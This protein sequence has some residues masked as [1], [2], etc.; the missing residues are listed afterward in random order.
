MNIQIGEKN[1]FLEIILYWGSDKTDIGKTD[2][3]DKTLVI[4][5]S[6]NIRQL[7]IV[8]TLTTPF[9]HGSFIYE[10]TKENSSMSNLIDNLAIYG[11]ISFVRLVGNDNFFTDVKPYADEF[12][13]ENIFI[14]RIETIDGYCRNT[15]LLKFS[16]ASEDILKFNSKIEGVSTFNKDLLSDSTTESVNTVIRKLF[17]SVNLDNK[18]DIKSFERN[19]DIQISYIN[20]ANDNLTN[21]LE[22]VYR[23]TFDD[24]F[25][26]ASNCRYIRILYDHTSG[27]YKQWSYDDFGT[28]KLLHNNNS[29]DST[30]DRNNL[31]VSVGMNDSA[32][33]R[34]G[35]LSIQNSGSSFRDFGNFGTYK[36]VDFNY[37]NNEF[38]T[39][40]HDV[41]DNFG[42][43]NNNKLVSDH[44]KKSSILRGN[45]KKFKDI[46]FERIGSSSYNNCSLYDSITNYIFGNSFCRAFGPGNVA[47]RAGDMIIVS[48]DESY[49]T[50]YEYMTG[51]YLITAVDNQIIFSNGSASFTSIM[52]LHKPYMEVEINK[53][54][55]IYSK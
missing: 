23:K 39:L 2:N 30:F 26:D 47:R 44:I 55:C 49:R 38:T 40:K 51:E 1:Y 41:I 15:T 11:K 12:F 53:R 27:L 14:T 9:F 20:S 28:D 45:G 3:R 21:A 10:D 54:N 52:D 31:R 48:F 43:V 4:L 29:I 8:S 18:L 36:F 24:N 33:S 13:I 22:Y 6:Q 46:V 7:D 37:I 17:A 34:C 50:A 32:N 5:K 42:I 16:F 35:L 25:I 19:S